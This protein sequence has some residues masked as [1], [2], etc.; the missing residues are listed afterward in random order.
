MP[1]IEPFTHKLTNNLIPHKKMS[2]AAYRAQV[3]GMFAATIRTLMFNLLV[4]FIG[5]SIGMGFSIMHMQHTIKE[6][7]ANDTL[8][9][10]ERALTKAGVKSQEIDKLLCE[11]RDK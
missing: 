10:L 3:F 2:K 7:Y 1:N 8:T 6:K 9:K 4:F 11:L 5:L